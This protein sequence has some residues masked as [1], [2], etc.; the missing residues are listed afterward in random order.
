[1]NRLWVKLL[2][3]FS[4]VILI[5]MI[6]TVAVARQAAATQLTH[7]MVGN[8]M[9]QPAALERAAGAYY[10]THGAWEGLADQF[11][12]VLRSASSGGMMGGM[13]GGGMGRPPQGPGGGFGR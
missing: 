2:V 7:F 13:M 5:G 10:A 4:A 12:A 11:P 1:M 3:A 9:V 8:L 6:V